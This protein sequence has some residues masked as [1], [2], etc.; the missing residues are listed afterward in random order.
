MD[1]HNLATLFG[2][3]ILHK[4]KGG[5]LQFQVESQERADERR[6]VIEVVQEMIEHQSEI[7]AVSRRIYVFVFVFERSENASRI[8]EQS[9]VPNC[10]SYIKDLNMT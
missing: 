10:Q 7:F 8:L 4:A 9:K 2:P 1:A 3:N 5:T 6:E